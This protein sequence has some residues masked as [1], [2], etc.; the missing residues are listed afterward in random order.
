MFSSI[1]YKVLTEWYSFVWNHCWDK[2]YLSECEYRECVTVTVAG[3]VWLCMAYTR[4][5]IG[6]C[7]FLCN[8]GCFGF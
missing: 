8:G 3:G 2:Y 4:V 5:V 6:V 7:V 1:I